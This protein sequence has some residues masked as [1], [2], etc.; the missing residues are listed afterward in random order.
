MVEACSRNRRVLWLLALFVAV[1]LGFAAYR[2]SPFVIWNDSASFFP[3]DDNDDPGR[4]GDALR[5][6]FRRDPLAALGSCAANAF[7]SVRGEGYRPLSH[8]GNSL[9]LLSCS[10]AAVLPLPLLLF[11]GALHDCW[12]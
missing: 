5:E 3:S 9:C 12:P 2:N 1:T 7:R 6:G 4:R 8:L 11:V 10:A